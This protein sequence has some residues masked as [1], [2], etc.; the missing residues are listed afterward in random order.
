MP[1][2]SRRLERVNV[3]VPAAEALAK[4]KK[5]AADKLATQ[6]KSE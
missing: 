3:Q 4:A 1:R 6:D 5:L 2:Q